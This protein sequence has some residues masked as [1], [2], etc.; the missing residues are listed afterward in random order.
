[1]NEDKNRKQE[2]NGSRALHYACFQRTGKT[3]VEGMD[4]SRP[5]EDLV[6]TEGLTSPY[7]KIDLRVGGKF[8]YFMR[9]PE[10]KEY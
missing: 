8:L 5:H 9:S 7:G 3:C 4:G 6:G 10:G 2:Y 1:M